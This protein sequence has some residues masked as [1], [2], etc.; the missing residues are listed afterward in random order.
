[1]CG[2]KFSVVIT[3]WNGKVKLGDL[4][5]R[6]L[7][8]VAETRCNDFEVV[9]LDNGS[10]DGS[11]E[12]AREKYPNFKFVRNAENLGGIGKNEAIKICEGEIIVFLDNDTIVD[13]NWLNEPSKLFENPKIGIVQSNLRLLEN[14]K[15]PD[16]IGHSIS[17]IGLPVE[18]YFIMDEPGHPIPIFGAK[19]AA[20]F[21][22]R[23]LFEELG[24]F[25]EDYFFYFEETDLC[26]RAR[27]LGYE[28]YFSPNSVV[29]HKGS[30]SF[31]DG[32]LLYHRQKNTIAS[33][34]KCYEVRNI[35]KYLPLRFAIEVA[36]IVYLLFKDPRL[37]AENIRA[38][39]WVLKNIRNLLRKRREIQQKRVVR[40]RE[41]FE[42]GLIVKSLS[43]AIKYTLSRFNRFDSIR[44]D[45]V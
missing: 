43:T 20:F 15:I 7:S 25:D 18:N 27:L 23:E 32:K 35:L 33:M 40:D 28:V 22:R 29:L 8:S 41:L 31:K 24:G 2:I 4:L 12:Y 1:M 42:K 30:G 44:E 10:T 21:I 45:R 17:A 5:N 34:I 14:P 6:C 11:Y 37:A 13:P 36:G 19:G 3:N 39:F 26:W 38:I 9:F 16:S